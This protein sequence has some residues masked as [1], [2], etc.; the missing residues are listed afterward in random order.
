MNAEEI[1]GPVV[2]S[3]QKCKT[4]LVDSFSMTGTNEDL[5]TVTFSSTSPNKVSKSEVL[6]TSSTG[7]DA[8]SS[9][10]DILCQECN[11]LVGKVYLATPNSLDSLRGQYTLLVDC[12]ISYELGRTVT[13]DAVSNIIAPQGEGNRTLTLD[14]VSGEVGK[15]CSCDILRWARLETINSCL[16]CRCNMCYWT[17]YIAYRNWKKDVWSKKTWH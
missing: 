14:E 6:R 4:I 17:Y 10:Y 1:N 2:F 5:R 3:C 12:L 7:A 15:V 9:F 13:N 11:T 16:Y 8:G